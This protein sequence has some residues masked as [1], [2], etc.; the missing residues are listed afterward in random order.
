MKLVSLYD[1]H[2]IIC[3]YTP[4]INNANKLQKNIC[5]LFAITNYNINL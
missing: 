2:S 1:V 3:K 5:V 4:F